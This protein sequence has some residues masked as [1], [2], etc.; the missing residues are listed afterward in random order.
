MR[1]GPAGRLSRALVGCRPRRWRERYR[2][3][4]LD[5]LDQH[6]PSARTVLNLAVSVLST[7]VDPAYRTE[8][9]SLPRLRR[10]ALISVDS[11][12]ARAD[13]RSDRLR[14][15]AGRPLAPGS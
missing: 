4:M 8:A 7:H 5:V 15:M 10:A 12:P 14:D 9:L 6:Q 1:T 11:G 3:E 13:P 2:E